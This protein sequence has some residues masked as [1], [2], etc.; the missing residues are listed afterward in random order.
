MSLV[1]LLLGCSASQSH[2]ERMLESPSVRHVKIVL[3]R[4]RSFGKDANP[5]ASQGMEGVA[6][7][8]CDDL[9]TA[10]RAYPQ[11]KIL[12]LTGG[13]PPLGGVDMTLVFKST[14]YKAYYAWVYDTGAGLELRGFGVSAETTEAEIR[15]WMEKHGNLI[16]ESYWL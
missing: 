3:D 7:I 14:P 13:K 5:C 11:D 12:I 1:A 16:K 10:A 6:S 15:Q 8:A 4:A 9:L 2:Y